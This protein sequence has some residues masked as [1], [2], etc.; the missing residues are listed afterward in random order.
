MEKDIS[1][2]NPI[3]NIP[4]D[5]QAVVNVESVVQRLDRQFAESPKLQAWDRVYNEERKRLLSLR[6]RVFTDAT[7]N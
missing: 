3:D 7:I 2:W 6:D 5:N 1:I 4:P